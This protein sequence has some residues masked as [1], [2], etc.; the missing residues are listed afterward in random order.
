MRGAV[1]ADVN[2]KIGLLDKDHHWCLRHTD[3]YST[4]FLSNN[5]V[6]ATINNAGNITATSF[7]GDGSNLTG[8]GS[9][10]LAAVGTYAWLGRNTSG[11]I[12]KGTSYAGSGLKYAG[13]ASTNAY[14]DNTAMHIQ[15][16]AP[17]GTWRAMGEANVSSRRCATLFIRIS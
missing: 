11:T 6:K 7:T 2:N 14:S 9:T 1:Y 4:E 17:A 3:M 8:V 13:S 12:L 5:V 15:G 10:T 16:S